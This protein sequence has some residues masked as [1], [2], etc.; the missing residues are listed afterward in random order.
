MKTDHECLIIVGQGG[1]TSSEGGRGRRMVTG[2]P[3][4][5]CLEC[6]FEAVFSK[7]R[8][9]LS[10]VF[11]RG[12]SVLV[13][14]GLHR[15]KRCRRGT[16]VVDVTIGYH[17]RDKE[18]IFEGSCRFTVLITEVWLWVQ[19]MGMATRICLLL[20]GTKTSSK[21]QNL[22]WEAG[23]LGFS[24]CNNY[25]SCCWKRNRVE[26]VQAKPE[27]VLLGWWL[28][29]FIYSIQESPSL[30]SLYANLTLSFFWWSQDPKKKKHRKFT[31]YSADTHN[32][33]RFS[34]LLTSSALP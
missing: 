9:R 20:P 14:H 31:F 18:S 10:R 22:L 32:I 4:N 13:W 6:S 34:S 30:L 21:I 1:Y 7:R 15:R 3:F 5:K 12:F 23:L 25:L 16:P 8:L 29:S 27:I 19:T 2:P 11:S 26:E 33:V 28:C 17:C 24:H